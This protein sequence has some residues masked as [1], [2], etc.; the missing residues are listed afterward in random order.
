M[1]SLR[2]RLLRNG[3]RIS[4]ILKFPPDAFKFGLRYAYFGYSSDVDD[5]VFAER[6]V[7]KT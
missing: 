5:F 6:Q 4:K 1:A 2:S 3:F 7:C